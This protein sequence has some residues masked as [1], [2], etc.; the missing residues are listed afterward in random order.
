MHILLILAIL[1]LSG[2]STFEQLF[3]SPAQK[4]SPEVYYKNDLCFEHDKKKHCGTAVL[5]DLK[6][7]NLR[8]IGDARVNL[9]SVI[10]CHRDESRYQGEKRK[11][12][13]YFARDF[14]RGRACPTYLSAFNKAGRHRAAVVV[15]EHENYTLPAAL[16]CNGKVRS[17]KGTSICQ[18]R[19]GLLQEI[20]FSEKVK[21]VEPVNGSGGRSTKCPVLPSKDG[22]KFTFKLPNRECIYGFIGRDSGQVHIFYSIGYEQIIIKD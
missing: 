17:T 8:I 11:F 21:A 2:C 12:K 9:F 4:L 10:T 13:V 22:K 3:N 15:F 6:D 7:V 1:L 20:T 5:P 14:E 16:R 19:T 18:S